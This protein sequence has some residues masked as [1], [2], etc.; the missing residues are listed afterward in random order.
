VSQTQPSFIVRW[1]RSFGSRA[2]GP[3]LLVLILV[4]LLAVL[5]GGGAAQAQV[6]PHQIFGDAR[7][8]SGA[9]IDGISAP[10]GTPVAAVNEQGRIVAETTIV[11]GRW[12]LQVDAEQ[13]EEVFITLDGRRTEEAVVIEPGALAEVRL[14]MVS[15]IDLRTQVDPAEMQKDPDGKPFLEVVSADGSTTLRLRDLPEDT[16]VV[17]VEIAELDPPA[18]DEALSAADRA[19]IAEGNAVSLALQIDVLD[20]NGVKIPVTLEII[21]DPPDVPDVQFLLWLIEG[22]TGELTPLEFTVL[23]DGRL[24]ATIPFDL[25]FIMLEMPAPAAPLRSGL[26]AVVYTGPQRAADEAF[27]GGPGR[28]AGIDALWHFNGSGYEAFFPAM[29]QLSIPI[30]SLYDPLFVIAADS[31]AV[32]QQAQLVSVRRTVSLATG[33]NLVS[34]TGLGGGISSM[35]DASVLSR[36]TSIW[37]WRD[38]VGAWLGFFPGSPDSLQG[39]TSIALGDLVF[40]NANAGVAWDMR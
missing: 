19:L 37:I 27:P 11:E 10:D 7:L 6:R 28:G 9:T 2:A 22:P 18:L 30:Y 31:S 12:T 20:E 16:G 25:I 17:D 23:E 24:S 34:Y 8:G 3:G 38:S 29:P 39:V 13:A 40:L 26:N 21:L 1:R 4:M 5:G 33:G 14:P 32:M 36:V 35:L 15:R